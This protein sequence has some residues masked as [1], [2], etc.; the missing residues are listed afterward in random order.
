ME[1]GICV[2]L[3]ILSVPGQYVEDAEIQTPLHVTGRKILLLE[4]NLHFKYKLQFYS[5]LPRVGLFD[6]Q[7]PPKGHTHSHFAEDKNLG[8]RTCLPPRAIYFMPHYYQRHFL[9]SSVI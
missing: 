2:S 9:N 4:L 7:T 1:R 5:V 3:P 8:G 6:S